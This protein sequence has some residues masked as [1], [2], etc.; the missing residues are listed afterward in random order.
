MVMATSFVTDMQA[1]NPTSVPQV[2]QVQVSSLFSLIN[3][4]QTA[5]KY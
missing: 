4:Q 5:L 2:Q 3:K 1:I